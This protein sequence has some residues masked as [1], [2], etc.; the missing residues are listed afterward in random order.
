MITDKD[1]PSTARLE[2]LDR[3]AG[4]IAAA[5]QQQPDLRLVLGH[6]SGSFG[7]VPARQY[8]TRQGVSTS[9]QWHGF[10]EVWREAIALNRLVVDALQRAELPA[11]ALPPSASVLAEDGQVARWDL[12]PLSAAL[13]HGLLPVVYGDVVFD[14]VRGGTILSTEDLFAHLARALRPQALAAGR[15]RAG[16]MGRLSS[17]YTPGRADYPVQTAPNCCQPVW[18][19]L[20]RCDRRDGQQ[21]AGDAGTGWRGPWP[22][23]VDLL[24]RDSRVG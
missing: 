11:M 5:F 17:L 20:H 12:A 19:S 18:V 8:G 24:R 1:L 9:A 3:L 13:D 4:E 15:T 22:G 10:I 16:G 21:S 2:V 14:I 6:G 23:S 7:H